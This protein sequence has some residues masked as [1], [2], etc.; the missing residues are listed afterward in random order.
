M[1]KVLIL[2]NSSGGLYSFRKELIE[3]MISNGYVV[4]ASTPF[5]DCIEEL[6]TLGVNLIQTNMDRRGMHPLKDIKLILHYRK[7]IKQVRPSLIITYTIKPNLYGATVARLLKVQYAI[8]ITGLG[9]VFQ[10]DSFVRKMVVQWYKFVCKKVKVIFF[11]NEGNKNTFLDFNIVNENKCCVLNGAGVNTDHFYFSDYPPITDKI[12]FLFIG[13]IMKEKGV[14]ELFWAIRKLY[15]EGNNIVLDVV[16]T[17][18]DDYE[19]KIKELGQK[20]CLHY[21]GYQKD[22]R[23][24]IEQCHCFI[25]PSYHEGMANTLLECASMGRPLITSDIHGCKE[26]VIDG[27]NGY[28]VKIKNKNDLYEKISIFINSSTILKIE[29]GK[30]SR[31]HIM[32]RFNKKNVV[33]KTIDCLSYEEDC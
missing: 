22:V 6:R 10:N 4:Y 14:D 18:E 2:A 27:E 11:E 16:G 23:P 26:A 9:T 15:D 1:K 28:L 3:K 12:H 30:V 32:T 21:Y 31:K 7:I 25:L 17:F 19:K 33:S 13:R 8:N 5:D 24:F 29:Q 20:G